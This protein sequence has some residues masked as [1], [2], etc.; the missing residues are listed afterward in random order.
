M[1]TAAMKRTL[2]LT[3]SIAALTLAATEVQADQSLLNAGDIVFLQGSS[4]T[5][6]LDAL[7]FSPLVDIKAGTVIH[8]ADNGRTATG[9]GFADWRFSSDGS[10]GE[11]VY[12]YVAPTNIAAGTVIAINDTTHFLGLATSGDNLLAFQGTIYNPTFIAGL[13]WG[14]SDS[15]I[16]TGTASSNNSYLPSSLTLGTNAVEILPSTFDNVGYTGT[17]SGTAAALRTAVN[18]A[19]NWTPNDAA[20]VAPPSSLTISGAAAAPDASVVIAGYSFGPD[21][22]NYNTNSTVEPTGLDLGTVAAVSLSGTLDANGGNGLVMQDF[23]IDGGWSSALTSSHLVQGLQ[24]T[25]DI[26]SGQQFDLTSLNFGAAY[27]VS[28]TFTGSS[29][30]AAYLSTDGINFTQLGSDLTL[31]NENWSAF[32]F[33]DVSATQFTGTLTFRLT[34]FGVANPAAAL[35]FDEIWLGGAVSAVPEPSTWGSL[36]LG[37]AGLAG[38]RRFRRVARS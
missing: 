26:L 15:F 25:V 32:T 7:A 5:A 28:G 10:F 19:S 18:T 21:S 9:T 4:D 24:F 33:N 13:G 12:T 6:A 29:G 23:Q 36:I 2:I 14:S 31:T 37:I 11:G 3:A 8:I 38:W 16:T 34:G 1:K 27:S 22:T 20:A 17:T 35:E 30:A